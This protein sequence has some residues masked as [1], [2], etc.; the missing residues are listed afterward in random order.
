MFNIKYII[1]KKRKLQ[2][3]AFKKS[4]FKQKAKKNELHYFMTHQIPN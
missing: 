2:Q 3:K 1:S 4:I